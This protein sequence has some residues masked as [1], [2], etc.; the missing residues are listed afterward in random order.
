MTINVDGSAGICCGGAG[1]AGNVNET[2]L[3][4]A[5]NHPKRVKVRQTVNT[6]NELLCCRDCRLG[7]Q[8]PSR[9]GSHIPDP[10]IALAALE[11]FGGKLDNRLRQ[12]GRLAG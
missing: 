6:A 11:L 10:E 12:G 7:K 9:I 5:W 1:S 3:I 8:N 2:D 4:T